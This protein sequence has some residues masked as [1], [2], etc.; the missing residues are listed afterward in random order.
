MNEI[1]RS[2]RIALTDQNISRAKW[3]CIY[4]ENEKRISFILITSNMF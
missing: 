3:F 4:F 2:I 1:D